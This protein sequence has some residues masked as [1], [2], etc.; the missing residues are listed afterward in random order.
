M[1]CMCIIVHILYNINKNSDNPAIDNIALLHKIRVI[2]RSE[3]FLL[4]L[5][6]FV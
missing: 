2:Q 1:A 4:E 3:I 6:V 5:G